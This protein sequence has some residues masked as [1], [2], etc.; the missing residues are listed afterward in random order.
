MDNLAKDRGV[1]LRTSRK[2]EGKSYG[3]GRTVSGT[4][5]I[6]SAMDSTMST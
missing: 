5:Y 1:G 2:L 3:G 6:Y 4:L